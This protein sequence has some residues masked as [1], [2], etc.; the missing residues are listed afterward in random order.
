MMI[1]LYIFY[2]GGVDMLL[3]L[4]GILNLASEAARVTCQTSNL[5][6]STLDCAKVAAIAVTEKVHNPTLN[7][8]LWKVVGK[9]A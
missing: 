3:T 2:K 5:V 6:Q 1:F 8:L 9:A 7:D 4:I